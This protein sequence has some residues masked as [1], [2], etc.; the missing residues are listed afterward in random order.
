MTHT[1]KD[2]WT[3]RAALMKNKTWNGADPKAGFDFTDGIKPHV[4]YSSDNWNDL[5]IRDLRL[6]LN[7]LLEGELADCL[8]ADKAEVNMLP[9]PVTL[10]GLTVRDS[11]GDTAIMIVSSWIND[12]PQFTLYMPDYGTFSIS[13]HKRR[14]RIDSIIN[15]E[16]GHAA[17][18]EEVT[19]ILVAL[20]LEDDYIDDDN[21]AD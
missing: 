15:T 3:K 21:L 14:G 13:W 10:Y 1:L 16:Y 18:L 2:I 17:V 6:V 8:D 11:D 9:G 20:G 4:E 5:M 19:D 12:Q 7:E